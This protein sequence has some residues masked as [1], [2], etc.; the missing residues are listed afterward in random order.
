MSDPLRQPIQERLDDVLDSGWR[1]ALSAQSNDWIEWILDRA[2]EPANLDKSWAASAVRLCAQARDLKPIELLLASSVSATRKGKDGFSGMSEAAF[3]AWPEALD[4]M[5]AAHGGSL[6]RDQR[7]ELLL[8]ALAGASLSGAWERALQLH[9]IKENWA[10]NFDVPARRAN[11]L[12]LV[13]R[14]LAEGADPDA[15]GPLGCSPLALA[16]ASGQ[17]ALVQALL[18]AGAD[19]ARLAMGKAP[20][21]FVFMAELPYS[22]KDIERK[23]CLRLLGAPETKPTHLKRT[24]PHDRELL[25]WIKGARVPG[26]LKVAD[27]T[28][29]APKQGALDFGSLKRSKGDGCLPKALGMDFKRADWQGALFASG[30]SDEA[31][32]YS[33]TQNDDSGSGDNV[34]CSVGV[35]VA[36]VE[37]G[38]GIFK[39]GEKVLRVGYA[40]RDWIRWENFSREQL[41]NFPRG[42]TMHSLLYASTACRPSDAGRNGMEYLGSLFVLAR[43]AWG[44][45]DWALSPEKQDM[46][47]LGDIVERSGS[48]RARPRI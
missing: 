24:A 37:K 14:L 3:V 1:S 27:Q 48:H 11:R 8:F 42:D 32:S 4:S 38:G 5:T 23:H 16:A 9:G 39:Q 22:G 19:K 28:P 12:A 6:S 10:H 35:A 15:E 45:F 30:S 41:L 40:E 21:A 20:S 17:P 18:T 2:S 33:W 7:S 43:Q 13:Q 31:F 36:T 25:D 29:W 34:S 44:G 47:A 26:S 46:E